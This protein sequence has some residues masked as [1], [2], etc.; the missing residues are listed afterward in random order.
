MTSCARCTAPSARHRR[1]SHHRWP[2]LI[3][4]VA[5]SAT[6]CTST[7]PE[8]PVTTANADPATADTVTGA[9][10]VTAAPPRSTSTDESEHSSALL[11]A[12]APA[13]TEAAEF[14]DAQSGTG[15]AGTDLPEWIRFAEESVGMLSVEGR[16]HW[17]LWS[18]RGDKAAYSGWH[19]DRG[20]GTRIVDADGTRLI[21]MAQS[22]SRMTWSPD[23]SKVLY[24]AVQRIT[25][26]NRYRRPPRI[27]IWG[28]SVLDVDTL[29]RN[30]LDE[31]GGSYTNFSWSP[32]S[33]KV[34]YFQVPYGLLPV[35]FAVWVANADGTRRQLIDTF[36]LKHDSPPEAVWWSP[37]SSEFV[38]VVNT[39][40]DHQELWRARADASHAS[41][42]ANGR[43]IEAGYSPDSTRLWASVEN[44]DESHDFL[45]FDSL[46]VADEAP[47]NGIT[48]GALASAVTPIWSGAGDQL[49][50]I[51]TSQ[52]GTS[53]L[54]VD[55]FR[56]QFV[57]PLASG[58][59]IWVQGSPDGIQ[60]AYTSATGDDAY[61]LRIVNADRSDVR[62]IVSGGDI[63]ARWSP[64]SSKIWY[65]TVSANGRVEIGIALADGSSTVL[66]H[67]ADDPDTTWSA[68]WSPDG[69]RIS[70]AGDANGDSFP[71]QI[72]IAEAD[73]SRSRLI[74]DFSSRQDAPSKRV[75][76]IST[77]WSEDS[78][79]LWYLL[80]GR[81]PYERESVYTDSPGVELWATPVADREPRLV[82]NGEYI[83]WYW[84]PDE[85]FIAYEVIEQEVPFSG[86]VWITA[87]NNPP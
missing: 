66:L 54:F 8:S 26:Y 49:S 5:I 13:T 19:D 6:A 31:S 40:A 35:Q 87:S 62:P 23:G 70:Y 33:T 9:V 11:E 30:H 28:P 17:L 74:A 81:E 73:G 37:D 24:T 3:L 51:T 45:L 69:S 80:H 16:V 58:E 25:E 1:W 4:A 14:A 7:R 78:T 56:N 77:R 46:F 83:S 43:R 22:P 12:V 57:E 84:S 71:E 59:D 63:A 76:G 50:F 42:L 41:F 39:R 27:K 2:G 64:D 52:D 32:D 36:P 79:H 44:Y 10:P 18:P 21:E 60:I 55:Y 86:G 15:N 65:S 47:Y 20:W 75:Q 67:T 61:E 29:E 85:R 34:Q 82:A 53:R 48:W 38:F 72:W 68:R